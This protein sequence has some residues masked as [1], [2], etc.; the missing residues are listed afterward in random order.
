MPQQERDFKGIW[1]PKEI[2]LSKALSIME[3][4]LL[5]EI[6]S[7]DRERGCYA[8]NS[9]FAEFFGVSERQIRT[10][11]V[12]PKMLADELVHRGLL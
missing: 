2:W 4:V 7:L 3:K 5:V 10:L 6:H 1:I 11:I 12:S 9:R 8:K